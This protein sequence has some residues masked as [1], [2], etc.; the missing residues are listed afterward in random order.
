[1]LYVNGKQIPSGGLSLDTSHNKTRLMACRTLYEGSGIHHSNSGPRITPDTYINGCFVLLFDSTPDRAASSSH[2][3]HPDNGNIHIE[4]IFA[5][6]FPDAITCPLYLEYGGSVLIDDSRS[7]TNGHQTD[8]M[9]S[10]ERTFISRN[11]SFGPLTVFRFSFRH[12]YR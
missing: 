1:V 10:E 5:K 2:T 9:H 3:W 7:V 8:Y 6:T 4:L 12:P 11:L